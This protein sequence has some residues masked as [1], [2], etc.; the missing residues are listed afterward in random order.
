MTYQS[1]QQD[2][3]L[4]VAEV[5][6][7]GDPETAATKLR[8]A[9]RSEAA[10]LNAQ[11]AHEG[12]LRAEHARSTAALK[13]FMVNNDA[14]NDPVIEGA[15]M[16]AMAIEQMRDLEQAGFS[17]EQFRAATGREPTTQDVFNLH[18][19]Y[20]ANGAPGVRS[21]E[22]L[23]DDVAQQLEEKFGVRRRINNVDASRRRS[24]RDMVN[25][26]RALRGLP[27][28]EFDEAAAEPFRSTPV[29]EESNKAWTARQ[30]GDGIEDGPDR[31]QGRRNAIAQMRRSRGQDPEL[32]V[33]RV[34][35]DY[36]YPDRQPA[37]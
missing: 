36:R 31:V 10:N 17:S 24:A 32:R 33:S 4:D 5:L 15:G 7:Y 29:T 37:A 18:L 11:Q 25:E 1:D 9:I 12:R 6:L 23:M 30:F 2:P 20:R 14:F 3:M 22:R 21:S 27:P 26:R 13:K 34:P 35:T 28:A 8:T 19:Q 16:T